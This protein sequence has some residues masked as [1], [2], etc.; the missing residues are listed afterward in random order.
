MLS[1]NW[2]T[3]TSNTCTPPISPYYLSH[4][5]VSSCLL[6]CHDTWHVGGLQLLQPD[7]NVQRTP[8]EGVPMRLEARNG[9]TN[10]AESS[11]DKHVTWGD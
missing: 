5:V 2:T 7:V 4:P 9:E 10:P 1:T 6:L 8:S 11:T 3:S